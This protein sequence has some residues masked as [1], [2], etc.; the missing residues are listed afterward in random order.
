MLSA[1]RDNCSKQ[2]SADSN[3]IFEAIDMQYV[4]RD[5]FTVRVCSNL[6]GSMD[7]SLRFSVA[8]KTPY[9]RP[10]ACVHRI[11]QKYLIRRNQSSN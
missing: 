11:L 10:A 3:K 9:E 5:M 8:H 6:S 1:S 4:D 7:D 2:L